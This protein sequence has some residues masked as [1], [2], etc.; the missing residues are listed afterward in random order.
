MY[1]IDEEDKV[2]ELEDV[3][4][5]SIGAPLPFVVSDEHNLFLAYLV[6]DTLS[7]WDGSSTRIVTPATGNEQISLIEFRR[8]HSFMFGS[9]NDEAFAGHPLASRGLHPYG[10]FQIKNSSWIRQLESMNSIHPYHKPE[11]YMRLNHYIF[12]FHDSTF[13]CVAE[14][15]VASNFEGSLQDVLPEIQKRLHW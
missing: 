6:E 4:P 2:I 8:S 14:G 12:A 3:P 7:D 10:A 11:R 13:E 9:P 5:S 15:Y 1:S